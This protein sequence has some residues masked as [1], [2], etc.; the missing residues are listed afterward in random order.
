MRNKS[1]KADL[2]KSLVKECFNVVI[3]ILIGFQEKALTYNIARKT[4][5]ICL[6]NMVSKKEEFVLRYQGLVDVLYRKKRLTT[7]SADN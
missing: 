2:K 1:I 6:V 5:A 4:S 7:N 3:D